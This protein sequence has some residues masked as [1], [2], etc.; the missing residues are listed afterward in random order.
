MLIKLVAF[1]KLFLNSIPSLDSF[2]PWT[3][4]GP[5]LGGVSLTFLLD[6]EFHVMILLAVVSVWMVNR[7]LNGDQRLFEFVPVSKR[8]T[9]VNVYLVAVVIVVSGYF[10]LLLLGW[11]I[12][13]IIIGVAYIFQLQDV[14]QML[15]VSFV[16][17][18]NIQQSLFIFL[19]LAIIL[20]VGTTI[21]FVRNSRYRN[22]SY[23]AFFMLSYGLLSVL[24]SYM[25][26]LPVQRKV[27]FMESLTIMPRINEILTGLSIATIIIL[28]LSIYVG[29]RL[30]LSPQ[31]KIL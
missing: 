5:A 4:A 6:G 23:A 25:P 11:T 24:K 3:F 1:Q 18:V 8:F 20:L 2:R 16:P 13:G 31:Q 17:T 28:P 7:N 12:I 9:F 22:G 26:P 19:L 30:Y 27:V 29:Y 14:S 15:P 21:S 10:S